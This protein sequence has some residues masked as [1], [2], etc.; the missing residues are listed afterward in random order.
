MIEILLKNNS[1]FKWFRQDDISFKGYFKIHDNFTN[2]NN[3]YSINTKIKNQDDFLSFLHEANGFFAIVKEDAKNIFAAVDRVRSIPLFY[4][5]KNGQ[6]YLSDDAHWIREKVNDQDVD[7]V[8][9]T[10]FLLTGYV[11]GK[12]T[13]Y[14]NVK[15]LQAGEYLIYNK[16]T[17]SLVTEQYFQFR[18]SNFYDTSN[19]ELISLLDQVHVNVFKRLVESL[20]GRT[21]VVPLSG[22]YDSRL[23]VVMLKRL[24]Y[25]NVICFSYGKEG[26]KE[27]TVS[28]KVAD[29]LGY[30]WIFIPYTKE[31]WHKWYRSEE[32]Q[33]YYRYADGLSSLPHI[34]D[35]IAVSEL[36]ERN[37]IPKDSIFI[38]G[39]S[40]DFVAGSHIPTS[41]VGR[42]SISY[43]KLTNEIFKKHYSLWSLEKNGNNFKER[44][45]EKIY[46]NIPKKPVYSIEEAAD[47]FECW[48][49]A[50]RQAKFICNSVRVYDFLDYE[51]RMPLWDNEIMAFWSRIKM[52]N[53]I[54][55]KLYFDYVN[56]MQSDF[57]FIEKNKEDSSFT[58]NGKNLIKTFSFIYSL[59]SRFLKLKQYNS[60]PLQ[61]HGI[62][63]KEEYIKSVLGGMESINSILTAHYLES[64]L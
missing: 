61:M 9:K 58:K 63:D 39:H 55:R 18:H 40:G 28:K 42:N 21:A 52:N 33:S 34:Q 62:V 20:D 38:P 16:E 60:H 64:N 25:E 6:F 56:R 14:P 36:K 8:S 37:L 23:I 46:S 11:T 17:K 1:G 27:S 3:P 29:F 41:F 22:G 57:A 26:N 10:E 31:R 5:K 51:W 45:K 13:L 50:E 32:K 4:G 59:L 35:I 53:R 44:F 48:D 24:G 12:D 47:L 43:K 2:S 49:W 7:E 19:E 54:S 15:Q 30:Q